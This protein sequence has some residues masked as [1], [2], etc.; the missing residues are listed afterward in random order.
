M[1]TKAISSFLALAGLALAFAVHA[2]DGVIQGRVDL[3]SFFQDYLANSKGDVPSIN[4]PA[5]WLFSPDEHLLA[6]ADEV[7]AIPVLSSTLANPDSA[8]V[9]VVKFPQVAATLGK[10]GT[11]VPAGTATQWTALVLSPDPCVGLCQTLH[12]TVDGLRKQH[13]KRLRVVDITLTL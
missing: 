3:R 11:N 12:Q 7:Q 10:L 13:P 2:Q 9:S 6:R 8:P 4:V 1:S 5:V